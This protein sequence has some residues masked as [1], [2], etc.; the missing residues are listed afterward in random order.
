[1][2]TPASSAL[3][4]VTE[5]SRVFSAPVRATRPVTGRERL[6]IA[7]SQQEQLGVF[8]AG[9]AEFQTTFRVHGAQLGPDWIKILPDDPDHIVAYDRR[10][11]STTGYS[12][13]NENLAP[14]TS[15]PFF[16]GR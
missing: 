14:L 6:L 1:M 4:L 12:T 13:L 15:P 10:I 11:D 8:R 16:Q 2:D 5:G 3:E 9:L 7:R